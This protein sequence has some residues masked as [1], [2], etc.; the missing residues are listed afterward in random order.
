MKKTSL[1]QNIVL[2]ILLAMIA[3]SIEFVLSTIGGTE[4]T[5]KLVIILVMLTYQTK[6]IH[7]ST[8]RAGK[9]T[10]SLLCLMLMVSGY[11]FLDQPGSLLIMSTA[12]IWAVRS[13]L[14]YSSIFTA[15]ADLLLCM[16][17]LAGF[18]MTV[19]SGGSLAL[20]VWSYFL[21]QSLH[22][23][24]P[25]RFGEYRQNTEDSQTVHRFDRAYQ[26]AEEAVRQIVKG[27][28]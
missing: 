7:R 27:A 10:L 11:Y 28:K 1:L 21:I 16:I 22:A 20:A 13:I 24:I 26:S 2:A 12:M 3:V 6:M 5:A 18:S 17:G 4:A 19:V 15:C 25:G 9:L 8:L 14:S 23:L